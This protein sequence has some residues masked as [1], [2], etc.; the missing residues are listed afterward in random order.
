VYSY[1]PSVS[2]SGGLVFKAHRLVYHSTL[3]WRVTPKKKFL[4]TRGDSL[5][6]HPI[7]AGC[8]EQLEKNSRR[9]PAKGH[10]LRPESGV[11]VPSW[12]ESGVVRSRGVG[13]GGAQTRGG[14]VKL[15][16]RLES[17]KEEKRESRTYQGRI[18]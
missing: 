13:R 16:S 10:T 12:L 1:L 5:R 8:R 7:K 9:L 14:P 17:N 2:A 18:C 3:G 15:L 4:P 6:S 11:F